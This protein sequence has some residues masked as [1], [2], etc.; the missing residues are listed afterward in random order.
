MAAACVNEEL[1]DEPSMNSALC[2]PSRIG[3]N[4]NRTG[5][6]QSST[7]LCLILYPGLPLAA[8]LIK[9]LPGLPGNG[10]SL[11]KIQDVNVDS[12]AIHEGSLIIITVYRPDPKLWQ[13]N[14]VRKE[15]E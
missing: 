15:Q 5:P 2:H 1:A 12:A 7:N 13:N 14:R 11:P 8:G 10:N 4:G 6:S 9:P 3:F